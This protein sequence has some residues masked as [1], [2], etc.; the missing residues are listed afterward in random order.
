MDRVVLNRAAGIAISKRC[1]ARLRFGCRGRWL[2]VCRPRS[3]TW[4]FRHGVYG[5][6][7]RS[8]KQE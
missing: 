8:E 3:L 4:V 2:A 6:S 7:C 1:F 5:W